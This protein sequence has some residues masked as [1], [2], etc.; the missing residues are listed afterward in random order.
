MRA[1]GGE[2]AWVAF[3]VAHS[4]GAAVAAAQLA[5]LLG[6]AAHSEQI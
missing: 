1:D 5:A 6:M 3:K 4:A 2:F